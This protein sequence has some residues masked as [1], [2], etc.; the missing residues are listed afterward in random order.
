MVVRNSVSPQ[1]SQSLWVEYKTN[2]KTSKSKVFTERCNDVD[3]FIR[4]IRNEPQFSSI[5]NSEITLYGPSGTAISV[6]DPI[7]S[8]VPGNSFT[9]PLHVQVLI[10]T[11]PASTAMLTLFWN[12]LRDTSKTDEFLHFHRRPKFFPERMKSLYV[13]KAYE[14]LFRII[15]E[16]FQHENTE[17]RLCRMAITGTPGTGKSIFLFYILWRLANMRSTRT[18]I[19]HRQIERGGIYVFQNSGCWETFNYSDIVHLLRDATT[20]YLTDSLE[21]PPALV[22]AVT[23][24][25]SSPAQK[26][27]SNFLKYLPIPPLHYLPIWSLEELKRVAHIYLKSPEEVEKRFDMIGGIARY[28]L[29][30]D[31]DLEAPINEAIEIQLSH[32]P[33]AIPLADG[34]RENEINHRLVHFRGEITLLHEI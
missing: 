30:E 34:S 22:D 5:K 31:D 13:R 14:D 7:S 18:V 3:D 32:I 33:V 28:V 19:L 11:D 15:W 17:K 4:K 27:Y 10:G 23:I 24:L 16:N 8:L 2:N 25:V 9:N 20:W 26:Y 29:E 1:M 6:G 12:S 21:P